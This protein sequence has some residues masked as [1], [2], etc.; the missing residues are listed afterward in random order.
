M[1]KKKKKRTFELLF[2]LFPIYTFLLIK[3]VYYKKKKKRKKVFVR[4]TPIV[5]FGKIAVWKG[6]TSSC[7]D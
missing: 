1:R 6:T 7:R 5:T 3:L 2:S 4:S